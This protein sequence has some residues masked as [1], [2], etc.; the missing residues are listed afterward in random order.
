MGVGDKRNSRGA[1][2]LVEYVQESQCCSLIQM[3]GKHICRHPYLV[4]SSLVAKSNNLSS[5]QNWIDEIV[6][7]MR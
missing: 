5:I 1:A 7:K 4:A 2:L 6:V 3:H